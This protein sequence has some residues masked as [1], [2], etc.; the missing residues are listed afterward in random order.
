M[1]YFKCFACMYISVCSVKGGQK[2][3]LDLLELHM[4]VSSHV[5]AGNQTWSQRSLALSAYS[6]KFTPSSRVFPHPL[7]NSFIQS[8]IEISFCQAIFLAQPA[9]LICHL[10]LRLYLQIPSPRVSCCQHPVLCWAFFFFLED[11]LFIHP[12]HRV[13]DFVQLAWC[14]VAT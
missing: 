7:S 4:G 9:D 1:L 13:N 3:A 11:S 2:R 14:Y 5:G 6:F 12:S 10:S 8:E